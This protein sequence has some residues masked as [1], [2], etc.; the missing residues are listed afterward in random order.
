MEKNVEISMLCQI[1]GKMLTEKQYELIN[2]YLLWLEGLSTM[3]VNKTLS[4]KLINNLYNYRFFSVVNNPSIPYPLITEI[5]KNI[6]DIHHCYNSN[7]THRH[8][9]AIHSTPANSP[10]Y[11]GSQ[12]Y[13]PY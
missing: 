11:V 10:Y 3:V 13:Y 8:I 6:P 9:E 12:Q 4:I 7:R 5:P 2:D 1:Y